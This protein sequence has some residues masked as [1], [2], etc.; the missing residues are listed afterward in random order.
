[1]QK[2]TIDSVIKDFLDYVESSSVRFQSILESIGALRTELE[3]TLKKAKEDAERAKKDR[4]IASD[5]LTAL[6]T[7]EDS[8]KN[9]EQDVLAKFDDIKVRKEELTKRSYELDKRTE[10]IAHESN[11]III[12]RAELEKKSKWVEIEERRLMLL[13]HKLKMIVEDKETQ[14]KLKELGIDI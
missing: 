14:K 6:D 3:E 13:N 11:E 4:Q 2:Q 12:A 1:M 8:I 10:A 9:A 7:R 5:R